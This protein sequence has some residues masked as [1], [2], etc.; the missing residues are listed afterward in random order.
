M[1]PLPGDARPGGRGAKRVRNSLFTALDGSVV[2]R[3]GADR[4]EV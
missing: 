3:P 1:R 2:L 4:V